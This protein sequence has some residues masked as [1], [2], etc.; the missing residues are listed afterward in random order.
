MAKDGD[1]RLCVAGTLPA[2]QYR[3][4]SV[5]EARSSVPY[6]SLGPGTRFGVRRL[7]LESMR[8]TRGAQRVAVRLELLRSAPKCV[9][10]L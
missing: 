3:F 4:A 6:R 8:T 7:S 5:D 2:S 1:P 9:R 10:W